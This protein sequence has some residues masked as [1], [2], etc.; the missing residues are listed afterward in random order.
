MYFDINIKINYILLNPILKPETMSD[1]SLK[2]SK[3]FIFFKSLINYK[4]N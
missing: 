4:I 3:K 2:L 1:L